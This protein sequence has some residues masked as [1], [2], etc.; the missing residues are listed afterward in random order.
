MTYMIMA[1]CPLSHTEVNSVYSVV[2]LHNIFDKFKVLSIIVQNLSS[3]DP[4]T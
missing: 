3:F 4:Q 1:V 2:I